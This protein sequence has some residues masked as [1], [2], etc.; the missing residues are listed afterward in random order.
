M[1]FGS[2]YTQGTVTSEE[3]YNDSDADSIEVG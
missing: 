3:D 1:A 2:D